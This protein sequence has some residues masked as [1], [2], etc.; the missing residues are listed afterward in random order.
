MSLVRRRVAETLVAS[1]G[2]IK[3]ASKHPQKRVGI[4][5]GGEVIIKG[6]AGL[7]IRASVNRKKK[8]VRRGI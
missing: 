7:E 3:V 6:E 1:E 8:L 5:E 4:G 2:F